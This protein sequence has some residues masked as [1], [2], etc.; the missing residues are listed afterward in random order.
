MDKSGKDTPVNTGQKIKRMDYGITS[1]VVE[2]MIPLEEA[3]IVSGPVEIATW[4]WVPVESVDI[5]AGR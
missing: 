2:R 1:I 5:T 4:V 3:L